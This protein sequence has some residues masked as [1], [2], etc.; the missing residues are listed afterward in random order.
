[1]KRFI[2]LLALAITAALAAAPVVQAHRPPLA[3]AQHVGKKAAEYTCWNVFFPLDP[4]EQRCRTWGIELD[5]GKGRDRKLCDGHGHKNGSWCFPDAWNTNNNFRVL[6][7]RVRVTYKCAT[8]PGGLPC[9]ELKS[10]YSSPPRVFN[11]GVGG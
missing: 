5:G 2:T 11:P 9:V 7:F 4:V 3:T 6:Q 1:M 10:F 8:G